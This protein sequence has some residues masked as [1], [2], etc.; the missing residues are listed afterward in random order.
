MSD[1]NQALSRISLLPP[2][3]Q[4][5]ALAGLIA[6]EFEKVGVKL[7]VVGG[8]A[9]QYYTNAEY[10][11]KDIDAILWGDTTLLVDQVMTGLDFKR[12]SSYRHFEHPSFPFVVEFPSPPLA[13]GNRDISEVNLIKLNE[14]AT[15]VIKVEDLILDR[16]IAGVEWHSPG[17]LAQARLL[18]LKNRRRHIN[19]RYLI[20]FARSEGYLKQLKE[21]MKS[22]QAPTHPRPRRRGT[23]RH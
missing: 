9:V 12:T 18:W 6:G 19:R 7:T 3:E 16:I 14:Y 8:A 13:V 23:W 20:D 10:T 22:P 11:T 21:I 2:T 5:I 17:H 4:Q 1:R 15:R